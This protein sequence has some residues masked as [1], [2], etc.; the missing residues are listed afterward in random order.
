MNLGPYTVGHITGHGSP[1]PGF[2]D[3]LLLLKSYYPGIV[4]NVLSGTGIVAGLPGYLTTS[5]VHL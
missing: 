4:G 2:L 5:N 1:S 3:L